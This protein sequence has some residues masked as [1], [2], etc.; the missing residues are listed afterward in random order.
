MFNL[1]KIERVVL[2]I[3]AAFLLL[4]LGVII[5]HKSSPPAP[6]VVRSF[7]LDMERPRISINKAGV[8]EL[9]RLSKIGPKLAGRI[10]DYRNTS[11]GFSRIEDIK[12]VKGIGDKL[13]EK[14]KDDISTE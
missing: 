7:N 8:Q 11:G 3:L 12:K 14:I 4:G 5:F 6:V 10:V 2:I 1:E 13:F 9:S